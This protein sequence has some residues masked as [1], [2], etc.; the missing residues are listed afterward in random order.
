MIIRSI[1]LGLILA[2]VVTI[3]AGIIIGDGMMFYISGVVL[4]LIGNIM[5]W[6]GKRQMDQP[7]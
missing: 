3:A 6:F 1:G 4:G 5:N 2:S 7:K